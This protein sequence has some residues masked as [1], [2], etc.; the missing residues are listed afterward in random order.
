M[1][2][3][4]TWLNQPNIE[5][6]KH[7]VI[8]KISAIFMGIIRAVLLIGI[9]YIII[10][11]VIKIISNS[12][13]D[14]IDLYNPLVYLVPLNYTPDNFRFA[15]NLLNYIPNLTQTMSFALLIAALQVLVAALVGYGFARF[16][17][18]GR[19]V[20]FAMVI[21][22]IVVPIQT[23]MI[24]LYMNFRFFGVFG[25]EANLIGQYTPVVL[26]TATGSGLRS[27]LY[28]YIFRQF[29]RGMPKEIEEAALIDGAG[30]GRTFLTVMLPNAGSAIITVVM[31]AL[32]WQY[33]DTFYVSLFMTGKQFLS[34]RLG[35]LG[36]VYQVAEG[37]RDP[38]AAELVVNAGMVLM[39]APIITIYLI[40]QRYFMESIER[41]GIVG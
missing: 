17:F 11:P 41:S 31:F 20:L 10:S 26:L 34:T 25:V 27:G 32:V 7:R 28:I 36:T 15:F 38:K 24:P 39:I 19:E 2:T 30:Q 5:N 12:I 22:T 14:P 16:R 23:Y 35:N 33:N 1:N 9:S 6:Y 13:K 21:I 18:P 29:F 3:I 8:R 37:I 40:M 4:S